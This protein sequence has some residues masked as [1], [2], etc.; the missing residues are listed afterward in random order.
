MNRVKSCLAWMAWTLG[1]GVCA[2]GA[3]SASAQQGPRRSAESAGLFRGFRLPEDWQVRFWA[4]TG[5]KTLLELEP[6]NLAELVPAQAGLRF[7]RCPGCYSSE[8]DDTL[9]W[10]AEKPGFL[11]CKR[12][13]IVLP[14]DKIPAKV[15]DKDGKESVPE[16]VFEVLPGVFHRYPYHQVDPEHQAYPDERLYLAAKC[17]FE[18]REFLAKAAMYAALRY[19]AQPSGAKD[20][21]LA[22]LACVLLLRFAQVYP[23]YAVHYDQPGEPKFFE[24]ADKPPPYRLGFRSAKWDWLGC[25]DVPLNLVI[26]FA[27]LRD[28][29][30]LEEA[31]KALGEAKPAQLIERKLL[32]ASAEFVRRQPDPF[33]ETSIYAYRGMLAVGRLLNDQDLVAE[34]AARLRAFGEQG[35]YHDGLWRQGD[36]PTHLRVLSLLDGWIEHLLAGSAHTLPIVALSRTAADAELSDSRLPEVRQAAWP[37]LGPRPLDRQPH[38][39]GGAGVARLAV[40]ERENALDLELKGLGS[41]GSAH[42]NRLALRLSV[43]GKPTLGDLD[44]RPPSWSGWEHSTAAH[45]CVLVDGLNQRESA[46]RVRAPA[47]GSDVLFFASEPN[48]QVTCLEDRHA[49]PQSATRYRHTLIAAASE[50]TRFAVSVFEVEGGLQHDQVFQAAQGM[51]ARWQPSLEMARGPDSLLPPSIVYLPNARAEEGRWFVQAY[52][53]FTQLSSGSASQPWQALLAGSGELG[54]RL[55][56]FT[57]GPLSVFSGVAPSAPE[58]PGTTP[59]T[60][61]GRGVLVIRRRSGAGSNL[62][63]TFVTLFEPVGSGPPLERAGR[64]AAPDDCVVLYMDTAEGPEHL[65]VNLKPG[66]PK[67]VHLADGRHLSTDG[68]AVRVS[69]LGLFLAGGTFADLAGSRLNQ[70]AVSG[71]IRAAVRKSLPGALGWFE[72]GEPIP[73][74]ETLAGRTL[75]IQHADGT[76]RGWTIASASNTP[77]GHARLAVREEPGFWIDPTTG[78]AHYYQFPRVTAPGPHHFRVPR[79]TFAK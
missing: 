21:K 72:T 12:C 27:L 45:N 2:L 77:T 11:T 51:G 14:N 37:A 54:V 5:A 23:A 7:C 24:R 70:Q 6:E 41:L 63:T 50:H 25:H 48:F 10:S 17:D 49:Y 60:E 47:L 74:A 33:E 67:T 61:L 57:S 28:N 31:G 46:D 38:L 52:G 3:A 15:K 8:A 29:P 20:P 66:S 22:R 9:T 13:G 34:A 1:I 16:E 40:G 62:K 79:V 69:P 53:A 56:V 65:V 64:V 36:R 26:A 75:L 76:T 58:Q 4:E 68:L 18:A 39:L 73:Q 19:D 55:H 78:Q 71:T 59:D 32:R 30:A 42:F 43:G 35:F 44:D